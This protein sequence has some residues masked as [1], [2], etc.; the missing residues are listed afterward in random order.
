MGSG[1]DSTVKAHQDMSNTLRDLDW[2]SVCQCLTWTGMQKK[3]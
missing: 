3:L 2:Y 1:T